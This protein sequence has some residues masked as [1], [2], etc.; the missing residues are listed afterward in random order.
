MG[1]NWYEQIWKS[2]KQ[3]LELCHF[4]TQLWCVELQLGFPVSN[5]E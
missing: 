2:L 5:P 3:Y 4:K 1:A